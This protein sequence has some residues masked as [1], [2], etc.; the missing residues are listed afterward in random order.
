MTPRAGGRILVVGATGWLGRELVRRVEGAVP[1]ATSRVL[2]EGHDYLEALGVG[3]GDTLVNAS[4]SKDPSAVWQVNLAVPEALASFAVASGAR[5]VHL[6]SAA[7]YGL[8][9]TAD[10][11]GE[12]DVEAPESAYGRAKLQATRVMR[13]S[14]A[15]TV[16]LRLFNIASVPPQTGSPLED[17]VGRTRTALEW[18]R[19][20]EILSAATT[21]DWVSKEFVLA[22]ILFAATHPDVRGVFNVASGVGTS[23]EDLVRALLGRLGSS[24][25][26]RDLGTFPAT[27]IVGDPARWYARSGLSERLGA[28][29]IAR[30]LVP[31]DRR[32]DGV[33]ALANRGVGS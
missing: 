17:V 15:G 31:E 9:S 32:R 7:E 30:L 22:S 16:V 13:D 26:V 25:G 6:G 28:E 20:V 3:P 10:R 12:A 14:A 33:G 21:R 23:M 11:V 24:T 18:D 8:S 1:V 27:A 5:I 4:G 2:A 19:D 29:G